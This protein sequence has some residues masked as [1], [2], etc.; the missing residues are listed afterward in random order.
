MMV[1]DMIRMIKQ[2]DGIVLTASHT[3]EREACL[4]IA[5]NA[6]L[7]DIGI[8]LSPRA[9]GHDA[10]LADETVRTFLEKQAPKSVLFVC[11]GYD[12]LF[13]PWSPV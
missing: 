5:K 6:T 10:T 8:Q 2:T 9:W 7:W 13:Y 11:F 3:L 4:A 12:K 1:G